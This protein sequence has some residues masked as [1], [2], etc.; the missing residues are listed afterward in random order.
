MHKPQTMAG[1]IGREKDKYK[2]TQDCLQQASPSK[3]LAYNQIEELQKEKEYLRSL[4]NE[5]DAELLSLYRRIHGQNDP[6]NY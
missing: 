2:E 4:L 6:S 1:Q 3:S 5:K